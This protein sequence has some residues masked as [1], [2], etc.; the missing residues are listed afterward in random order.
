MIVLRK[1]LSSTRLT[2]VGMAL[3]AVGASLIYGNPAEVP[4]WVL[5]VPL[6]V[7]AVNLVAAIA[8]NPRINRRPGLLMFHIGLLAVV[9]LVGVGRLTHYEA[10]VEM[11]DGQQFTIDDAIDV[12]SGPFHSGNLD[13]VQFSQG[14]FTVDYQ[15][16]LVRGSTRSH[17]R[18]RN[19]K[20]EWQARV[21]G[22]DTPLVIDGYRF[23]TTFNKGFTPVLTWLPDAGAP[24]TGTVNMPSYPLFDFKQSNSWTPVGG[25]EIKFWLQLDT[26]LRQDAAWTLDVRRTGSVLVVNDGDRRVELKPGDETVLDGGRL[27][28]EQLRQWMG[29]KI[30][31]DPTLRWLFLASILGVIGLASHYWRT[32]TAVHTATDKIPALN[33]A[34][35]AALTNKG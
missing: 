33:S 29:Y 18:V 34:S 27:R 7:L 32:F 30:F 2:I 21:I 28:Y 20:G 16:M 13:Q 24:V 11:V 8:T 10:H 5:V 9:V 22:D 26:G 17:I 25:R 12:K 1:L 14:P 31:F 6:S 3:L 4:V 35:S 19:E 23:Y 15:P